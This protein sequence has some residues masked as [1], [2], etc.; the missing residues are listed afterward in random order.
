MFEHFENILLETLSFYGLDTNISGH[1]HRNEKGYTDMSPYY[2]RKHLNMVPKYVQ[3]T[4]D[5]A[6]EKI[7]SINYDKQTSQAINKFEAGRILKKYNIKFETLVKKG[8]ARLGKSKTVIK[9][10]PDY[11]NFTLVK[12]MSNKNDL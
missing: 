7:R 9:Y 2:R 8:K 1:E 11:G 3:K 6:T 5:T 4:Q 10:N 12:D